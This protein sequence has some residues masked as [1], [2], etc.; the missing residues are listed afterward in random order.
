MR[1]TWLVTGCSRG[2]SRSPAEAVVVVGDNLLATGRDPETL[3]DLVARSGG[4]VTSE[5]T[6]ILRNDLA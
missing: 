1:R 6:D 4:R 5:S 2:L 3:A